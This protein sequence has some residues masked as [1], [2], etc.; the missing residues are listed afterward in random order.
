MPLPSLSIV[1]RFLEDSCVLATIAY[2]LSRVT[3]LK[4]SVNLSRSRRRLAFLLALMGASDLIF[5]GDRYPYVPFTLAASFAGY[6]GG[7][8]LGLLCCTFMGVMAAAAQL[9]GA[10]P[11]FLP[12][13][14]VSV[15]G[16]TGIGSLAGR[17][18]GWFI[19]PRESARPLVAAL[20][21]AFFAGAVGELGQALLQ[22]DELWQ[23][24]GSVALHP[25]GVLA[26]VYSISANGFGCLV[27]SLILWDARERQA[28]TVRQVQAERE[29]AMLRLSQLNELQAR[30]HP[31]FLFNALAGIAGLCV[32]NPP[33]AER[34][35]TALAA[36]LRQ[37]LR[38]SPDIAI[39]LQ[40]ELTIV[41]TYLSLEKLRFGDKMEVREHLPEDT[42]PLPVPR[43]CLQVP[44]ENAV[45]HGLAPT[46]RP[47]VITIVARRRRRYLLLAVGDNGMGPQS[48]FNESKWQRKPNPKR[49]TPEKPGP[50]REHGLALLAA[51]LQLTY[52]SAARLRLVGQPGRGSLCV[53]RLPLPKPSE[54]VRPQKE[55]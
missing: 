47:G 55:R 13:Y 20:L 6:T 35:V 11:I 18:R 15:L 1:N 24:G 7:I 25:V 41:R 30:L 10:P 33:Q 2:L 29:I 39:P 3:L 40:E 27:L 44:V 5:P 54:T 36:L 38:T 37:F 8:S 48:S 22:E 16:A 45:Q 46:G 14:L 53:L 9:A 4:T 26:A 51:R 34:G 23:L 19:L 52:G 28:M 42:L 32:T 50:D 31:H 49:P 12:I 17:S 43:F 21:G